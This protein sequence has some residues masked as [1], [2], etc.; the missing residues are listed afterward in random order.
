MGTTDAPPT[1]RLIGTAQVAA[2]L[3]VTTK[4]VRAL[5]KEGVLRPVRLGQ[6]PQAHL[7]F[8]RA[9]IERLIAG[10]DA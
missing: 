8:R 3:G 4:H 6:R 1:P 10:E 2:E 9:D 5:V 7:H